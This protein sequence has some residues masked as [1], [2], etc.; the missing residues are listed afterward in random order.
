MRGVFGLAQLSDERRSATRFKALRYTDDQ[1][2][3]HCAGNCCGEARAQANRKC[4][5]A[6]IG[7]VS[8]RADAK[9]AVV[10]VEAS[11]RLAAAAQDTP[12]AFAHAL[13]SKGRRT[14]D[15]DRHRIRQYRSDEHGCRVLADASVRLDP[16][17]PT[18]D[19][20]VMAA[21][22]DGTKLA[23]TLPY[24]DASDGGII[25]L[26]VW[27]PHVGTKQVV[28]APPNVAPGPLIDSPVAMWWPG[29]AAGAEARAS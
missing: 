9:P 19:P 29:G 26:I 23:Y 25:A 17:T 18:G 14:P 12:I 15:A 11:A 27:T 16:D 1:M 8:P 20:L 13:L 4:A 22:H 24:S 7:S 5:K 21:S 6:G 3:F 2:A 10:A 28:E